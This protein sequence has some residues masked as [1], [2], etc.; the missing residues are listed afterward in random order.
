M[1]FTREILRKMSCQPI[2]E[3]D[4]GATGPSASAEPKP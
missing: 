4:D 1:L 3:L 2:H